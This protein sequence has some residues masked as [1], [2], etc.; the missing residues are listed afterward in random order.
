MKQVSRRAVAVLSSSALATF[1]FVA[2]ASASQED[3]E[4][5]TDP[6]VSGAV[7]EATG[8][9][10]PER[11]RNAIPMDQLLTES[12][13]ITNLGE[14]TGSVDQGEPSSVP[15]SP[16]LDLGEL[17]GDLGGLLGSTS[18][19]P[20]DGGGEVVDT[21]GRVFFTVDGQDASCSGNAV[22]SENGSTVMT[23]GHCVFMDGEW[24]DDW[25][26]VPGFDNGDT[27]H[28][29]WAAETTMAIDEWVE[30]ED[31]DYDVGAA[32]VEEQDGQ[33]LT[34]V[35]GG[36]GIAFN[37][38]RGQPMD[39][40]GYP[41]SAPYDGSELIHCSGETFDDPLFSDAMGIGCDMT[42]GSSGGPWFLNFDEQSGTG[43]QNS[44]NSFKYVFLPSAMFGPY[45]GDSAQELYERAAT[46]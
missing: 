27:P 32:V 33:R 20:W 3:T 13:K 45:F 11:M 4:V 24:H 18:G 5:T 31:P 7:E 30:N 1:A 17:F 42:G 22:S 12:G 40:F 10:T 34:D 26:F 44:V 23:A 29:E 14:V 28:G 37:Q 25:I 35:V 8:S 21:A 2:P 39:A 36:Q 38:D 9:W 41:A 15:P 19:E 43:V 16:Q 6:G 46:A